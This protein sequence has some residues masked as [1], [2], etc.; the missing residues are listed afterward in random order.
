MDT[1][2]FNIYCLF[3][4]GSPYAN[5]VS[6]T[7]SSQPLIPLLRLRLIDRIAAVFPF[8]GPMPASWPLGGESRIAP[9]SLQAMPAYLLDSHQDVPLPDCVRRTAGTRVLSRSM[10]PSFWSRSRD[11]E[12]YPVQLAAEVV[13]SEPEEPGRITSR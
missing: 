6:C 2:P 1:K 12:D 4:L 8:V 5:V 9:L 13:K 7:M 10:K 11:N 3:S